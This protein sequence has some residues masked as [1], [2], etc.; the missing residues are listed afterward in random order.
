MARLYA[1]RWAWL[2]QRESPARTRR[3][4]TGFGQDYSAAFCAPPGCSDAS[5]NSRRPAVGKPGARIDAFGLVH[6]RDA[7][8]DRA[9]QHAEIAADAFRL[10][11][12][13]F[14]HAVDLGEDRLMRGV[15][16]DDVAAA[17]FDA[18][19]LV[20]LRLHDIVE[21]QILP[22]GHLRDTARPR[23]SSIER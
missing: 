21:V 17:A 12:D 15:L 4:V 7:V 3:S 23:K 9:D 22:V 1:S 11:D 5:S 2:M 16:A 20:D 19:V 14:S 18:E 13:E 8:L 10:V 6:Q